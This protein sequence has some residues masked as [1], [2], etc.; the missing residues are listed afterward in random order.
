MAGAAFCFW[1]GTLVPQRPQQGPEQERPLAPSNRAPSQQTGRNIFSPSIA[2]DPYVI[3]QWKDSIET[4]ER[5]C[6]D[7]NEFCTE[8]RQARQQ[9]KEIQ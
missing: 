5:R 6:R 1:L 2:N 7:A 9:I 8:A 3:Q 4:L